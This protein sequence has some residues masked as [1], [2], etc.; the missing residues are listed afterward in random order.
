MEEEPGG[1]SEIC[2]DRTGG[3]LQSLC[4]T[5]SPV[6]FTEAVIFEPEVARDESSQTTRDGGPVRL[7][8]LHSAQSDNQRR[9]LAAGCGRRPERSNQ[10]SDDLRESDCWQF[11]L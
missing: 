10:Q 7:A 6:V 9:A 8:R 1:S 2:N 4:S 11:R 5:S 3:E